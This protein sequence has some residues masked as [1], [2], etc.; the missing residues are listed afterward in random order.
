MNVTGSRYYSLAL[1]CLTGV[2]IGTGC[3]G[4]SELW[5]VHDEAKVSIRQQL[6][7]GLATEIKKRID[8]GR[9]PASDFGFSRLTTRRFSLSRDM[10]HE[11]AIVAFRYRRQYYVMDAVIY[12]EKPSHVEFDLDSLRPYNGTSWSDYG[13]K[14]PFA[15]TK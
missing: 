12:L 13:Q 5:Q 3:S 6:D 10:E 2:V 14:G 9:E 4:Q 1:L 8:A 11:Q 7:A 15:K